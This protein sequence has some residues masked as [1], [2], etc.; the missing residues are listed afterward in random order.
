HHPH[1]I[2]AVEIYNPENDKDR[3]VPVIY[4][5]G[6]ITPAYGSAATVLS[7]I[8]SLGFSKG[9]VNGREQTLFTDLKLTPVAFMEEQEDGRD[10]AAV[11]PLAQLNRMQ[12]DPQTREYVNEI[13]R[14][15]DLVLGDGWRKTGD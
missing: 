3:S 13:N 14:Y 15:A 2:Q 6:N 5:L 12:L 1:V 11:I 10:F 7:L 9:T 4:S 8:A